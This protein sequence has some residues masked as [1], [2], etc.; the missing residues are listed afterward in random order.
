VTEQTHTERVAVDSPR[1]PE[2]ATGRPG[3]ALGAVG[4][5]ALMAV[6]SA[7]M[8]I[9]MP[10]GW[11]WLASH[12]QRGATPS[13]GPY[14]LVAFGLPISMVLIAIWLRSLDR[15]FARLT[16]YDPNDRRIPLPW[17]KSMRDDRA[18]TRQRTVLDVVMIIS[19]IVAGAAFA[20]WFF[21]F[22]GS[23]LPN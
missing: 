16:G 1:P 18:R 15:A 4:L 20:V 5:V 9:G 10:V 7:L 22:A 13:L 3:V 2:R 23:S 11:L 21:G 12:L 19:V 8:W 14:M 6:G 17:H